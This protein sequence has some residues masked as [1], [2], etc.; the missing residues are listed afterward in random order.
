MKH[1]CRQASRLESDAFE[2]KLAPGERL[3]LQFHLLF[4]SACRHYR[5]DL[6]MMQHIFQLIRTQPEHLDQGM[7]EE[8]RAHILDAL[9]RI[10]AE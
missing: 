1:F 9:K 6:Q 4:C 7:S 5:R 2:R 3:R 10:S 8:D